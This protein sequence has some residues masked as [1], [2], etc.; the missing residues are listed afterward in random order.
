MWICLLTDT[1]AELRAT[2]GGTKY[3]R[4][5]D[6]LNERELELILVGPS[7]GPPTPV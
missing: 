2:A 3:W 6:E 4:D 5:R 7:G 1:G